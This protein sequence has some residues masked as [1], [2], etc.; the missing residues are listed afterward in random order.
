MQNLLKC[1]RIQYFEILFSTIHLLQCTYKHAYKPDTTL[2]LIKKS[3]RQIQKVKKTK[4]SRANRLYARRCI[5]MRI[6][7]FGRSE[8]KI[9]HFVFVLYY[10]SSPSSVYWYCNALSCLYVYLFAL[11]IINAHDDLIYSV[12]VFLLQFR[13]CCYYC[14]VSVKFPQSFRIENI[15][16]DL[17]G[18][19]VV[20]LCLLSLSIISPSTQ[21][22]YNMSIVT[23]VKVSLFRTPNSNISLILDIQIKCAL[24]WLVVE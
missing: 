10:S 13:C 11:A 22:S 9:K 2:Q 20:L 18:F 12:F 24:P 15:K 14:G 23:R 21:L 1:A 19:V 8:I 17:N 3:R 6:Y 4:Q 7:S 16:I 5:E